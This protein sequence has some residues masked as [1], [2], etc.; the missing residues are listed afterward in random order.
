MNSILINEEDAKKKKKEA[1]SDQ[2]IVA[3]LEAQKEVIKIT[4]E[5]WKAISVFAV[6]KHL[7]GPSDVKVLQA[8]IQI[9]NRIPNPTECKKLLKI[10]DKVRGEGYKV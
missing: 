2:K 5:H 7:I 10:L 1:K 8:A 6:E 9:P 3:G 4:G